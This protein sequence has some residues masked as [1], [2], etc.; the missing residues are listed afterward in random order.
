MILSQAATRIGADG[1]SFVFDP[2]SPYVVFWVIDPDT[3]EQVPYGER[4]QVVM[5]HVSK[6]MFIPNNLERDTA[7][8]VQG[9]PGPSAIRSARWRPSRCSAARPV[10]EGVY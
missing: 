10:I 8:R 2:R 6:G 1:E 4:G 5:N 9:P 3:G 7:I